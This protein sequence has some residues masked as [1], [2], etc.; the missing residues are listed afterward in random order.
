MTDSVEKVGRRGQ[1]NFFRVMEA[2]SKLGR[3]GRTADRRYVVGRSKANYEG[4]KSRM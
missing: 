2:L 1:P 3:G 4:N